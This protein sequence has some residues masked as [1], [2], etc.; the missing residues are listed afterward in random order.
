MLVQ[1][2]Y[3]NYALATGGLQQLPALATGG[4][5]FVSTPCSPLIVASVFW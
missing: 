4:V 3:N 5:R 2:D 1:C